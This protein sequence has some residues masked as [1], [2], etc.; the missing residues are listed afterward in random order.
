[1]LGDVDASFFTPQLPQ[2]SIDRISKVL[3]PSV[4]IMVVG[5]VEASAISKMYR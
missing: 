4:T 1:V 2:L 3:G 5:F